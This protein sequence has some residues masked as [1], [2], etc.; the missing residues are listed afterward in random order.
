MYFSPFYAIFIQKYQKNDY[1]QQKNYECIH[2]KL[3]LICPENSWHDIVTGGNTMRLP[4]DFVTKV[5]Q[6]SPLC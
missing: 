1:L 5:F 3:K 4:K 2:R 6:I